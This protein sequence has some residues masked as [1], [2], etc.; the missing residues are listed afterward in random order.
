V[1][2]QFGKRRAPGRKKYKEL[3]LEE[4]DSGHQE[5]FYE[6]KDHI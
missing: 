6:V 3:I 5:R 2:K 4:R 1:L